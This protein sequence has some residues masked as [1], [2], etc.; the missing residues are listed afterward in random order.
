MPNMTGAELAG[1]RLLFYRSR[2]AV[3]CSIMAVSS[4]KKR[5]EK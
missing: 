5:V 4:S 2:S 1:G 3:C